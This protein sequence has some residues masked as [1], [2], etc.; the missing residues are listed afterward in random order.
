MHHGN[1]LQLNYGFYVYFLFFFLLCSPNS[2]PRSNPSDTDS[3]MR[4]ISS[5]GKTFI[6]GAG[7]S[8]ASSDEKPPMVS[9]FSYDYRIDTTLVTQKEYHSICGKQ[10]VSD[11]SSVGR[12]DRY[13]VYYVSWFDAILFCNA[14][15]KNKNLDTVYSYSGAPQAHQGSVYNLVDVHQH[16][17]RDGYRLP[18]ESEWEYAAREGSSSLPFPHLHDSL[19]AKSYAWYSANASDRTHEVATLSPNAFGLYDMAGNVFEWTGDWKGFYFGT[20]ITNSIG[21]QQPNN[22]NERVVKGGSYKTGFSTLRPSHRSA[23]YE[24]SQSTATAYIGFRCARGA[25][26]SPSFI[27]ADTQ[28]TETNATYLLIGDSKPF[29]RTNKARLVF[30][31]VTKELRTLCYVDFARGYPV[32]HEFKDRQPVYVP[33]IS[34]NGK[35]TAFCT[36]NDGMGDSAAI[37]VRSLD[38]LNAAPIKIPSDSAFEPRWWVDPASKDTL[39]LYTNSAIDNASALWPSTSTFMVKMKGGKP[40]GAPQQIIA[41]GSYHDGRSSDGRFMATGFTKLIM[42]DMSTGQDR[43]LFISPFNGKEPAGSTQVCNVSMC[44][45]SQWSGR[46]LFIDFGCP[47]PMVSTLTGTSYGVHEY[48][49]VGDQSGAVISWF[50]CPAGEASWNYP[51]WSTAGNYAVACAMNGANKPHAIY[52]VNLRDS[53]SL[54]AVEGEELAHPFLWIDGRTI[55]NSDSLDLDSLGR[56][57][58]PPLIYNLAD[59]TRRMHDFWRKHNAM[60]IVFVGSSQTAQGIDPDFFTGVPVYNMAF[61]GCQLVVTFSIIEN[62][63][64]NHCPSIRFVGCDVIPGEMNGPYICI[65]WPYLDPNKGYNYD[66]HH[67]FWKYGLPANFENLVQLAPC[68]D[69]PSMDTLGLHRVICAN[70][71]GADPDLPVTEQLNWTVA[72]AT[73]K[74]NFDRIKEVARMLTN[75]GIHFLLYIAPQSP[76]YRTTGSYGLYGPNRET[77]KAVVA[78]I[79]ALQDSFP[80]SVHFYD[81]NLDGYHDY[82]DSEAFNFDHLCP[83]GARK[84]SVRIDS[85]MHAILGN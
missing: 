2:P 34:P 24:T 7:D 40:M 36:R 33:V 8:A 54:Q 6:Q 79:K 23:V 19:Q 37:Y 44:P 12:G 65:K 5:A 59:F 31:N 75:K 72:D 57:N 68:P 3:G 28:R 30:V 81:A 82:V 63:L 17:D 78:Q 11:T 80:F 45:D 71:G 43:Q 77:G 13:P 70:W 9:A 42:R 48:L 16:Y 38:S 84:F 21:A 55:V 50:R 46:C 74:S 69:I 53:S 58:D 49:F 32:V 66:M 15:S 64:L 26:P 25:I 39:L 60:Q 29:L 27:S 20:H 10:P 85:V 61:S 62:Y 73:Y 52:F 18:T 56:Y 35:Y 67:R 41:G 47:E 76:Q 1:P 83:A 4:K 22:D 14:K 51:E